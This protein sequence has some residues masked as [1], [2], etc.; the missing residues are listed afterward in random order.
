VRRQPLGDA[1]H[2]ADP[3]VDR[4]VDRIAG[5]A[6]GDEHHG[7]VGAGLGHGFG[8][9]VEDR[10]T[11]DVAPTLPGCDACDNRGAVVAIAAAVE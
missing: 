7:R 10:D 2:G 3:C 5:E 6:R 11:V 8:D 4:L 9:G 1:D